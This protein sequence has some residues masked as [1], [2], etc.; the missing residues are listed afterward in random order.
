MKHMEVSG[1]VR[2]IYIY[3][4]IYVIRRL[5]VNNMWC[6]I[7]VQVHVSVAALPIPLRMALPKW[8]CWVSRG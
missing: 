2:H 6:I 7:G 4:Y 5:K 8:G 1:A 3:I